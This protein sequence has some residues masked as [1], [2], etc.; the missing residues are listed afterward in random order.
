MYHLKNVVK[1]LTKHALVTINEAHHT[2]I[3][4]RNVQQSSIITVF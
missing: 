2:W 4:H 1:Y 3:L